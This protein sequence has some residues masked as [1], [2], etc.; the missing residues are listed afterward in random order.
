MWRV[1]HLGPHSL[2]SRPILIVGRNGTD[3]LI[4]DQHFDQARA[5]Q[6]TPARFIGI[7]I[8]DRLQGNAVQGSEQQGDDCDRLRHANPPS[9]FI[10]H[11]SLPD[12]GKIRIAATSSIKL[13]NKPFLYQCPTYGTGLKESEHVCPFIH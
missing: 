1:S 8:K 2:R 3:Q 11:V 10:R 9:D 7:P 13:F 12:G 5:R 4:D 6:R